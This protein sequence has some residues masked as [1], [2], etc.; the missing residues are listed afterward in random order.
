MA[1]GW[2]NA[3]WVQTGSRVIGTLGPYS[4]EGRVS[5]KQFFALIL[6]GGRV[7]YTA[8]LEMTKEGGIAGTAVSNKLADDPEAKFSERAP[9]ILVRTQPK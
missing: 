4:V 7:H 3:N 6:S 1:G 5:G 9:I 2:G 8:I